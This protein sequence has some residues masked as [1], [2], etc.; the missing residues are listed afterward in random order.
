MDCS[1]W[2]Y[3]E[4]KNFVIKSEIIPVY[5][6]KPIKAKKFDDLNLNMKTF[7]RILIFQFQNQKNFRNMSTDTN[8]EIKGS[9]FKESV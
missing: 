7:L 8:E 6:T 4:N 9:N 5:E 2:G 3:D 1:T